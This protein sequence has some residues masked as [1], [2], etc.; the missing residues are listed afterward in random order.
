MS[1]FAAVDIG[2]N[3]V[4]IKI[5][6]VVRHRLKTVHEDRVVTRLGES[7]F[8]FGTLSPEAME[9]T[10]KVLRRFYRDIQNFGV[11]QVR[12]VATSALRDARNAT[13]FIAWVHSATGWKVETISGLEE[14]RLIHLGILANT[15]LGASR[16]L[17]IDLGGGS[18]ELTLSEKGHIRKM[19]SL[20]LGAVRL[21]GEFLPHDP[22]R[23]V[24]I[25][26]L[27]GSIA[28][29][30]D[31]V[32][33]PIA[34]IKVR[35]VLA[36]SGT[37]AAISNAAQVVEP[38]GPRLRAGHVSRTAL[39][40]LAEH[41][42][43]L[44]F[45]D[46][47]KVP[48]I[49]PRRAEIIVAGACVFAELMERCNLPG[50]QYS[51]LGLRDGLLAQMLADHDRAT[52]S[53]RQIEAERDDAILAMC[54]QYRVDLKRAEEVRRLA[55]QLFHELRRVHALP[56]EY[57]GWLS[58]AALL[59]E[60]GTFINRSGSHRHTYYLIANSEIFG[61]TPEQR[62]IIAAIAR[63]LG[64]TRPNPADGPMKALNSADEELVPKAVVLLRLAKAMSHGTDGS[65]VN[66]AAEVYRERVL[67]KLT[68]KNGADL[69]VWM[70]SKE[71]AYF[72]EV[73]GRELDVEVF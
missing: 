66:V 35:N 73:F 38:F 4:R 1:I 16:A 63:Y 43:K 27:R 28:E 21:T 12:L 25:Q 3:S 58:A 61:F 19:V 70:L 64:K 55:V 41:L 36:T 50:F 69:E 13:A 6:R 24:E 17:L 47:S 23:P 30:L 32:R 42:A 44:D 7:V 10:V 56:P 37:A 68:A 40:R 52:V 20:P 46:R 33:E 48:G 60:A 57:Q 53:H 2:S 45:K 11:D 18:C 29:E 26:R 49:G 31:R 34:G 9:D 62:H 72:R 14:G 15:A 51:P 59:H 54:K 39:V 5:A 65:I 67:L 8:R 22:P 71:R